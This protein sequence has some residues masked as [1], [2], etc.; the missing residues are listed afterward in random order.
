MRC[1]RDQNGNHVIQKCIECVPEDAIHFIISTF[2]DLGVT[3]STHAYGCHVIQRILEHCHDKK[4]L[5]IMMDEILRSVFMLAQD[6]YGNYVI[7]HTLEHGK[8]PNC[9]NEPA[10]ACLQCC[11][12]MFD[13]W[14]SCG[15]SDLISFIFPNS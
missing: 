14:G 10:K 9:S 8:P 12:E 7:Q 13:F 4:T 6:Q 2:Y 15:A 3:L 5:D 1:V 11:G